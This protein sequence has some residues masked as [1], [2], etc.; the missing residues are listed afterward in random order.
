MS[1]YHFAA[2]TKLLLLDNVQIHNVTIPL[3]K[4]V[5]IYIVQYIDLAA[6]FPG[7]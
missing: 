4:L 5:Y 3:Y 1:S 2:L 7:H 6:S